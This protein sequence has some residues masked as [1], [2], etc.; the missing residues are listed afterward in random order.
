MNRTITQLLWTGFLLVH[1]L[2]AQDSLP[3]NIQEKIDEIIQKCSP[4]KMR[5]HYPE[6]HRF[7]AE[8]L[9]KISSMENRYEE[10]V[11]KE[12]EDLELKQD[13]D[14]IL[15]G[16]IYELR[17]FKK[18]KKK[19]KRNFQSKEEM[20]QEKMALMGQCRDALPG[21][22]DLEKIKHVTDL[23]SK[24]KSHHSNI[25]KQIRSLQGQIERES[26][27]DFMGRKG[28]QNLVSFDPENFT[29]T[30]DFE[31]DKP[32][33]FII[34]GIAKNELGNKL[35]DDLELLKKNHYT[36]SVSLVT[37]E[38]NQSAL[39]TGI[40]LEVPKNLHFA[41]W[42]ENMY[43]CGA[44]QFCMNRK[45]GISDADGL[46]NKSKDYGH[47]E[48]T[49]MSHDPEALLYLGVSG[50]FI[51]KKFTWTSHQI[52]MERLRKMEKICLERKI[53]VILIN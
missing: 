27:R 5:K 22:L 40:I 10:K 30:L 17:D 43:R 35:L 31:N 50:F 4:E 13:L 33:R 15:N 39:P 26:E 41:N 8:D 25:S 28:Y 32:F 37:E 23:K 16:K 18:R 47:N 42:P 46:I 38:K 36:M 52:D 49:I 48:L 29:S 45:F 53:P 34:H 6:G 44:N 9:Q 12:M 11:A 19:W 14:K 21:G 24:I 3:S 51:S 1:S 2:Q 20:K 7:Y